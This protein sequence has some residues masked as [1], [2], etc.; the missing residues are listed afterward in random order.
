LPGGETDDNENAKARKMDDLLATFTRPA[1]VSL[2][3]SPGGET[4]DNENAKARKT[5]NLLATFTTK[6]KLRMDTE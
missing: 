5:D 1:F 2:T 3:S 4:D 6:K